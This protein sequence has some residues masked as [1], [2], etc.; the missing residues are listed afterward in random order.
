MNNNNQPF[1][2]VEWG[3]HVIHT[4]VN[5]KYEI[6]KLEEEVKKNIIE[7]TKL[8]VLEKDK[9]RLEKKIKELEENVE[10]FKKFST[11]IS[12]MLSITTGLLSVSITILIQIIF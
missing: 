10:E 1:S 11:R 4:L 12:T 9:T 2:W 7:I 8:Q 3:N 6:E 5:N